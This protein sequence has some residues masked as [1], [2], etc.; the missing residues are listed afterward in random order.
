MIAEPI[1]QA[2]GRDAPAPSPRP[3]PAPAGE[4]EGLRDHYAFK[5]HPMLPMPD[6]Q[7]MARDLAS[8]TTAQELLS[9][10][11][12]RAQ[13]I[14]GEE[15]DP[16]RHG[17]EFPC[18]KDARRL[19]AE[20]DEVFA[21]GANASGKTELAGKLIVEFMMKPGARVLGVTRTEELSKAFQ[22]AAAYKYLPMEI[23]QLAGRG[24]KRD[25]VSKINY[26]QADG[27]ANKTF[28]LPPPKAGA[29]GSQCWF[30]TV[31]QWV[32][33]QD[34]FEGPEYDLVV[35]DEPVPLALLE[36]L[37]YRVGKRGGKLLVLFTAKNGYD[38][39]CAQALTGARLTKSFPL[40]YNWGR[41][42]TVHSPESTVQSPQSRVAKVLNGLQTEILEIPEL[43]LDEEQVKGCPPGHMPYI[44]QP[45]NERQAVICFWTQWNWYLPDLR[46]MLSKC[47]RQPKHKVRVRL[48]GWVEKIAGSPFPMFNPNVHVVP[49]D[50]IVTMMKERKL[51]V[52]MSCDPAGA[53]S[54]F[55][56]WNGVDYLGRHFIVDESPRVTDGEWV[57]S[58]GERGD[59]Q[60]IFA[61]KGVDWYKGHIRRREAELFALEPGE[62]ETRP[63][64]LRTAYKRKGDPRAFATQAAS[65]EGGKSLLELFADNDPDDP[66]NTDKMPM[67]FVPAKVRRTISLEVEVINDLFAY[68]ESRPISVENEPHLY[69]SDRC[70]NLISA[71]VNWNEDQ[72]EDSPYKDPIDAL[73]YLHDEPMT[74]IDPSGRVKTHG[75]GSY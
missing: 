15:M 69:V 60:Y 72:G 11:D 27:F 7:Q 34:A 37:R 73:R 18:W 64:W 75:G 55:L 39:V 31:Q 45:L 52:Y 38:A 71:L 5:P 14:R 44:L 51:T 3:S 24:L 53:R 59:G 67:Q 54:Y 36:T 43:R 4:G 25:H 21:L 62:E 74:F 22:Q 1:A 10:L 16:F 13:Q 6:A 56:L 58:D 66:T 12:G 30:K 65:K 48:F 2:P 40:D 49:H 35:I 32:Q 47:I 57:T 61:A 68:D 23:K 20:K 19:L 70:V 8:P 50:R 46:A 17:F 29:R 33:D 63:E 9:F 41:E 42:S 28:V 26:T